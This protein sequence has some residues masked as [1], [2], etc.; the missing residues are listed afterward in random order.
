MPDLIMHDASSRDTWQTTTSPS[1][2]FSP[3]STCSTPSFSF[4]YAFPCPSLFLSSSSSSVSS[5][6]SDKNRGFFF[7]SINERQLQTHRFLAVYICR[8]AVSEFLNKTNYLFVKT[9]IIVI[10]TK[11]KEKETRYPFYLPAVP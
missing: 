10:R 8:T 9:M 4:S 7:C 5:F 1:A 3:Y 6:T 2:F 11:K